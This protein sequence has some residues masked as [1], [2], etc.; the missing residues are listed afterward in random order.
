MSGEIPLSIKIQLRKKI[1]MNS[2]FFTFFLR[3]GIMLLMLVNFYFS[4]FGQN[5]ARARIEYDE[6]Q[7]YFEQGSY[8]MAYEKL[9]KAEKLLGKWAPNISYLKIKS[10][11]R[12]IGG[13]PIDQNYGKEL[14]SELSAYMKFYQKNSD[15][16][17]QEKFVE[18]TKIAD[19]VEHAEKQDRFDNDAWYRSAMLAYKNNKADSALFWLNKSA[20]KGNWSALNELGYLY[21]KQWNEK[22]DDVAGKKA[23]QYF[24]L[25]ARSGSAESMG[26]LANCY[27]IGC[28]T[29]VNLKESLSW[30]IEGARFNDCFSLDLVGDHSYS[31]QAIQKNVK[32][33]LSSFEWAIE[34]KK[35]RKS[36]IIMGHSAYLGAAKIYLE[37]NGMNVNISKAIKYLEDG[38]KDSSWYGKLECLEQLTTIY[39]T[40]SYGVLDISKACFYFKK[41]IDE[42]TTEISNSEKGVACLTLG[43]LW[44]GKSGFQ[45]GKTLNIIKQPN[46]VEA[47]LAFEKGAQL[48]NVECMKELADLYRKGKGVIKD[49]NK[50][51]FWELKSRVASQNNNVNQ[52]SKKVFFRLFQ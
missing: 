29:N 7:K 27:Y 16:I 13:N 20:D 5:D 32:S 25:G 38:T 47:I 35:C 22:K 18:I 39:Y 33:A 24:L 4:G 10:L 2:I 21:F 46:F 11:Y 37:N 15:L 26:C 19:E 6:G 44:S 30:A 50:A 17:V 1:K 52:P 3:K 42:V 9:L 49:K 31:G 41:R 36:S 45:N 8:S 48:G 23:F 40:P 51:D 34:Q 12:I 43:K 14:S 28:G